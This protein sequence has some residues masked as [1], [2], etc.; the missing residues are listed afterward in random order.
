MAERIDVGITIKGTQEAS[1]SMNALDQGIKKAGSGMDGLIGLTDKFTGGAATG[2]INAYKGTLSFIK[3]LKLTKVA[4][5]STGI[6]AIVVL[7]GALVAAFM[8]S[9]EQAGQ[10]KVQMAKLGAVVDR[11]KGY[12]KAAGGY[13]VGLFS[14]GPQQALENYNKEMDKLPGSMI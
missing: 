7:V 13:I 12:F 4:L 2:M 9:E 14:G 8:S 1:D 3:G 5:I 6:G 11:V 10:M